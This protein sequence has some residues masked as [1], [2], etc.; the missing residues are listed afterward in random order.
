LKFVSY[1]VAWGTIFI[2]VMGHSSAEIDVFL[3]HVSN[4]LAPQVSVEGGHLL[5]AL[6]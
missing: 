3:I 4:P 1:A 5:Y 2:P 6:D